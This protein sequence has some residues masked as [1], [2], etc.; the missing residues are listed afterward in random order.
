MFL[1]KLD[2]IGFINLRK[3]QITNTHQVTQYNPS[4]KILDQFIC[5]KSVSIRHIH[6]SS[7]LATNFLLNANCL[8]GAEYP[9]VL[10]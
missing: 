2:M 8:I 3:F 9:I 6:V 10:T 7:L 1:V 5:D 4:R